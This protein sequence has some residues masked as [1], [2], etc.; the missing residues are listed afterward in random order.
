MSGRPKGGEWNCATIEGEFTTKGAG[1]AVTGI[2]AAIAGEEL[3]GESSALLIYGRAVCW[4]GDLQQDCGDDISLEPHWGPIWRQHSFSAALSNCRG[5]KQ[6][7]PGI[8]SSASKAATAPN[9][10][11]IAIVYES[12]LPLLWL[13]QESDKSK[14]IA[15]AGSRQA[16]VSGPAAPVW[17]RSVRPVRCGT[18]PGDARPVHHPPAAR[19]A[20]HR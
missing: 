20:P 19:R 13:A 18:L 16:S 2:I 15:G 8:P 4:L 1:T 17:L 3:N 12:L 9:L 10:V 14:C 7:S 6:E 5:T 11:R